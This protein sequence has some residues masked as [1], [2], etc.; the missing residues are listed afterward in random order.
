MGC[1]GGLMDNAFNYAHD[2]ALELESDY[3]YT[4]T[5]G[6]CAYSAAKGHVTVASHVDVATNNPS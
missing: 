5:R 3:A 1:N 4:G 6:S 2:Y